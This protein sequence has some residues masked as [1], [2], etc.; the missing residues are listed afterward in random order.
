MKIK[1]LKASKNNPRTINDYQKETLEK[2]MDEFGD[3]SGIVFNEESGNLIGGHQRRFVMPE[4]SEIVIEHEYDPPTD[5]GTTKEGYVLYKGERFKFR[6]VRYDKVKE[7]QANLVAN[8][9]GGNWDYTMLPE[10]FLELD[11]LNADT[12]LTGFSDEEIKSIILNLDTDF[13][14]IDNLNETS[15]GTDAVIKITC[16]QDIKDE[17]LIYIKAK[18]LET[19][20]EGVNVV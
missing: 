19:S 20:F 4:D 2:T 10:I 6:Q 11:H 17:V 1:E 7:L 13:E 14:V 8:K 3:L 5:K 12:N 16:P 9:G 18:L 15:E